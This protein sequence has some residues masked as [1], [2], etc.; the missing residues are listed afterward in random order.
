MKMTGETIALCQNQIMALYRDLD[1]R[2]YESLVS[3]FAPDGVWHRQGKV[4]AGRDAM[5]AALALRPATQRIHHLMVNVVADDASGDHCAMRAYMV[6]V[7]H[8]SGK[9]IEGPAPL[10]GI[11]SIR[12]SYIELTK[13]GGAWLV[14]RMSGDE[15]SF[16]ASAKA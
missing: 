8:D 12:T 9:A 11:E 16:A 6:V 4:L 10:S 1:E 13:T 7:R 14:S 2:K 5:L 15:P 3:R